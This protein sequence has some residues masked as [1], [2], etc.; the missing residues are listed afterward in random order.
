LL[1]TPSSTKITSNFWH[2]FRFNMAATPAEGC[3][4]A[5]LGLNGR[6]LNK[7]KSDVKHA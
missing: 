4:F 3:I 2:Y 5:L 1:L 6:M 7:T